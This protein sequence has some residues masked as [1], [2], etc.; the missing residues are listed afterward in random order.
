MNIRNF[1]RKN[2]IPE[3]EISQVEDFI[4]NELNLRNL[5]ISIIITIISTVSIFFNS[6]IEN[7][8]WIKFN[9]FFSILI[10]IW[11]LL[12]PIY[13]IVLYCKYIPLSYEKPYELLEKINPKIKIIPIKNKSFEITPA[14]DFS[15]NIVEAYEEIIEET[16]IEK[17]TDEDG[18]PIKP[19]KVR[20][21]SKSNS[22]II[23]NN[24]YELRFVWDYVYIKSFSKNISGNFINFLQEHKIKPLAYRI[25]WN[26]VLFSIERQ[27]FISPT[28]F[29]IDIFAQIRKTDLAIKQY[30]K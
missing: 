6:E 16:A 19:Y 4:K 26:E 2:N 22:A 20:N 13:S 29:F 3:D 27:R 1:L 21:T 12:G 8:F 24:N 28:K 23:K 14:E 11:S 30:F 7:Y 5:Y 25:I 15:E 9:G 10:I 17:N 18:F